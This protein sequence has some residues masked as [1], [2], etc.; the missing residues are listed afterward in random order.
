MRI[1]KWTVRRKGWMLV[2]EQS[3]NWGT[4]PGDITNDGKHV[5]VNAGPHISWE[6]MKRHYS[7]EDVQRWRD[8]IDNYLGGA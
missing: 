1:G 5:W 8:G 3:I 6:D 2:F 7:A 4:R